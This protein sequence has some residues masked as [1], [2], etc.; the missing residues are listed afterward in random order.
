MITSNSIP[1]LT[2]P[3]TFIVLMEDEI[4]H[5]SESPYCFDLSCPCQ[6]DREQESANTMAASEAWLA[7]QQQQHLEDRNYFSSW[8]LHEDE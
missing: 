4:I 1:E 7:R 6:D 5:T 2:R 3:P 8:G